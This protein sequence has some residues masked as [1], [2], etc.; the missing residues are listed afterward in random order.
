MFFHGPD[1]NGHST[2]E[3]VQKEKKKKKKSQ[4]T[5]KLSREGGCYTNS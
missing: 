2:Y 5:V 1:L 4:I 3:D